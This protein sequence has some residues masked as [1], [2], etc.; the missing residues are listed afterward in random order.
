MSLACAL[1]RTGRRP[2]R[3]R[4]ARLDEPRHASRAPSSGFHNRSFYDIDLDL[5]FIFIFIV[6][7]SLVTLFVVLDVEDARDEVVHP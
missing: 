5:F 3:L 6:I 1:A 4:A 7:F 2:G